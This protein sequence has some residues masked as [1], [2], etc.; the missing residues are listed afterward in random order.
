[1]SC[2]VTYPL[3]VVGVILAMLAVRKM[4]VRPADIDNG[5]HEDHNH[6]FIATYCVQ[7]PGIYGK[8]VKEVAELIHTKFVISRLWREK[9]VSIPTSEMLLKEGDRL[10]DCI[11]QIAK[12]CLTGGL[13]STHNDWRGMGTSFK[14]SAAPVQLDCSLGMVNAIQEAI[15]FVGAGQLELLPALPAQ[16]LS[17]RISSRSVSFWI[18]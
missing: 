3:G 15:V 4:F 14:M 5:E 6:T 10:M 18:T 17:V 2:A 16:P 7:N 1:M 9:K 13:L 11:D 12:A 8:S